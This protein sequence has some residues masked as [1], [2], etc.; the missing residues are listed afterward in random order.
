MTLPDRIRTLHR[1]WRIRIRHDDPTAEA[2]VVKAE[3]LI[4]RLDKGLATNQTYL[5]LATPTAAQ[6][7][8][9]VKA[10][11]R[12]VSAMIRLQRRTLG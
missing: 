2:Q 12:Q 8:A 11:T 1:D 9:H 4:D 5:D 6:T 10:L 7:T 3:A